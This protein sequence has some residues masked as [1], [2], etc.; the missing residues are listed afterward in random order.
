MMTPSQLA[1]LLLNPLAKSH[2]E[3]LVENIRVAMAHHKNKVRATTTTTCARINASIGRTCVLQLSAA[4]RSQLDCRLFTPRLYTAKQFCETL[5]VD[6]LSNLRA[7][8]CR[9]LVFGCQRSTPAAASEPTG[10]SSR[11]RQVTFHSSVMPGGEFNSI[12]MA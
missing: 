5:C 4:Q 2:M 3:L 6:H 1:D 12:K 10:S 11:S 7:Y 9:S 8:H